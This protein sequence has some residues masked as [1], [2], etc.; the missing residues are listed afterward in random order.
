MQSFLHYLSEHPVEHTP[1][2]EKT[3]EHLLP[4]C[5]QLSPQQAYAISVNLLGPP[6]SVGYDMVA[7]KANFAFP[8]DFGPKPRS[9]V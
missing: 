1:S 4:F 9:A 8:R 3:Y 6:A 7:T 2:Y 5:S